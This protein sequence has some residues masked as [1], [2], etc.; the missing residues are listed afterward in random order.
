MIKTEENNY[1]KVISIE[2]AHLKDVDKLRPKEAS[3]NKQIN[4]KILE[5]SY[6]KILA[7]RGELK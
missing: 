1:M 3:H 5:I 2:R 6:R 4:D 7:E